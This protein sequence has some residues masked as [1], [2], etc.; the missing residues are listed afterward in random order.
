MMQP[1]IVHVITESTPFGG[2]QR[3]T[4]LTLKGLIRD[5]Y[6]AELICGPGGPLIREAEA[7]KIKV[8]TID[9]LIRQV[10]PSRDYQAL[11]ILYKLF[12]LHKY[13]IVHTH[14]TK[15]GL[16]GRLAAWWAGIPSIVHTVHGVPF[17]MNGNY[18]SRVYINLEWL[19]GLATDRVICV[20]DVLR[21]EVAAWN[22]IPGEKLATIYSGIDFA[23]YIPQ[24]TAVQMKQELGIEDAWP[25][26]GCIG[27]LSEQKAQHILIDAIS[28]LTGKY[29]KIKLILVGDGERYPHLKKQIF[30]KGIS[31]H[32]LLLGDRDDIADLLNIFNV[33]AMSSLWEGVGR[34]LTEAMYWGLPIVATP[35]NGVKEFIQHQVTGLLIPTRDPNALASSID[36]LLVDVDLAQCISSNAKHKAEEIMGGDQM[37][38][39]IEDVYKYL[40]HR[41]APEVSHSLI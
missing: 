14:S 37:I 15:A 33:Y 17:E 18:R 20:G 41:T 22:M 40:Y 19:I 2:A 24:R 21:Q 36:R 28:Y 11:V 35:V 10:N 29:P 27:R 5:G 9:E 30:D 38:K 26:V 3:N 34:A 6:R 13:D 25:I 31:S 23:G 1:T 7:I 12:K 39:S 4:L 16:L 32:I 8:H